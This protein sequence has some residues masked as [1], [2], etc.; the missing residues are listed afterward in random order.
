MLLINIPGVI[1]KA[2]LHTQQG[3]VG[4]GVLP[5]A[6]ERYIPEIFEFLQGRLLEP[7][8]GA[9]GTITN[10]GTVQRGKDAAV[11]TELPV[12]RI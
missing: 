12:R 6:L 5:E 1:K 9:Y 7:Y 4:K 2:E 10:K 11:R 8:G 3:V